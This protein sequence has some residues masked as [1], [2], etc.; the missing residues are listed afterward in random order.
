MEIHRKNLTLRLPPFKVT[1]CHRIASRGNQRSR[2]HHKQSVNEDPPN[3]IN[4]KY[5]SQYFV[6]A[7]TNPHIARRMLQILCRL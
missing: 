5:P 6:I 7:N 4:S 2:F 3:P 1:R